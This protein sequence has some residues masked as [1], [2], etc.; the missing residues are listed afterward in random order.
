MK[1]EE[2]AIYT[3]QEVQKLL[4]VKKTT[5]GKLIKKGLRVIQLGKSYRFL[6]EDLLEFLRKK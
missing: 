3:Y 6:G 4:G 1:I 2:K 5:L